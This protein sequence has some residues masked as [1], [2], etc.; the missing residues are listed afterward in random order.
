MAWTHSRYS[1]G[2]RSSDESGQQRSLLPRG[3]RIFV[4]VGLLEVVLPKGR[5][6]PEVR[7]PHA[8]NDRIAAIRT[9]QSPPRGNYINHIASTSI[10]TKRALQRV[11]GEH[12]RRFEDQANVSCRNPVVSEWSDPEVGRQTRR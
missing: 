12:D 7:C 3:A 9:N 2:S 5:L 6:Y 10:G 11:Q 1:S 8:D 4:R